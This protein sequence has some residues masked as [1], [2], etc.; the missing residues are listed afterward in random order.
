M[1]PKFA[2]LHLHPHMRS[3]NWLHEP[4]KDESRSK[5]DPWWLI[6]PNFKKAEEGK[7]AASYS[8]CDLAQLVNGNMKLAI[9][10][11]YPLEKGWV[12]GAKNLTKGRVI[13]LHKLFGNNAF[14]D[15]M[16]DLANLV[17]K[18]IFFLLGKDQKQH[19]AMRDF[20]QAI[21]MKLP[22]KKINFFQS[23]KYNYFLELKEERKYLLKKNDIE[24]STDLFIP[25]QK[26]LFTKKSKLQQ[27]HAER[28]VAKGTYVFAKNGA[29]VKEIIDSGK[30]AFVLS[31]E[32]TNVF[33]T[34]EPLAEVIKNIKEVK[35]WDEPLLF[36]TFSHHFYNY[37]GGQ[38]HSLPD[39]ANLMLDQSEGLTKG[40]TDEGWEVLRLLLSLDIDKKYNPG[41]LGKRILIDVKHLNAHARK[42]YYENIIE[43]CLKKGDRIPV[44]ASHVAYSG[45]KTLVDHIADM[46]NEKDGFMAERYGHQFNA[47]NINICDEDILTIFKT[48]GL[49]GI[50]FDQ[51]ILGITKED[52]PKK[53]RHMHYFWQNMKS[54]M[55]VVLESGEIPK[56]DQERVLN[57]ISLG[58]DFDGYIDPADKYAT[59]LDLQQ[60]RTDLI[61]EIDQD[62]E[63]EMFLFGK[64]IAED[65]AEKICF[66]NAYDFVVKNF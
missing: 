4:G 1:K 7:R 5:Y 21:F 40:F 52:I 2:D 29:H 38:A 10:S 61:N 8:Q 23:D 46:G 3:F 34:N 44:I 18:P 59:V 64:Y 33:N 27:E 30:I 6:L 37:L 48:G 60:F 35:K 20:M 32:G 62:A 66:Q 58:S 26:K 45:R 39:A 49:I 31:I 63:K 47:W 54:M 16:S 43:P 19:I 15:F 17:A 41:Q 9:V 24:S 14:N 22:F 57:M 65:L 13:D 25:W 56:S 53:E 50:N 42:E 11:L 55:K 51:R 28:L 12:S 36:I